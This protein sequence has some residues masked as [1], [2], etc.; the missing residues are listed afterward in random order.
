[1]DEEKW[2]VEVVYPWEMR[3]RESSLGRNVLFDRSKYGAEPYY[4]PC[5][6]ESIDG[7]AMCEERFA[8]AD[9]QSPPMT[10]RQCG[11][12]FANYVVERFDVF[13]VWPDTGQGKPYCVSI[14]RADG[15]TEVRRTKGTIGANKAR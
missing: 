13:D 15:Q 3:A 6:V 8:F 1:M 10:A 11:Y 5:V 12:K 7:V 2:Y 4:G 14:S 9:L